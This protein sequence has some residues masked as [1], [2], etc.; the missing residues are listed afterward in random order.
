M[1]SDYVDIF[2]G[3][4]LGAIAVAYLA[5]NGGNVTANEIWVEGLIQLQA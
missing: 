1:L 4:S 5:T 3:C 2:A